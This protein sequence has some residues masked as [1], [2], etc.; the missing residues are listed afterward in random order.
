[1][2]VQRD[3]NSKLGGDSL[4]VEWSENNPLAILGFQLNLK[5]KFSANTSFFSFLA[6]KKEPALCFL[7]E[8]Y[9]NAS[10]ELVPKLTGLQIIRGKAKFPRA[11]ILASRALNL[12]TIDRFCNR[13]LATAMWETGQTGLQNIVVTSLYAPIEEQV[14]A[15]ETLDSLIT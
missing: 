15:N 12:W 6:T 5:H 14:L 10:D 9:F 3:E 1:M 13:D 2:A 8:P 4:S 7:S 11:I